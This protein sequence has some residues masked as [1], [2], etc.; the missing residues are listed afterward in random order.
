MFD[1]TSKDALLYSVKPQVYR[2]LG[3]RRIKVL[4]LGSGPRS[5]TPTSATTHRLAELRHEEDGKIFLLSNL[6]VRSMQKKILN[7]YGG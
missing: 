1:G 6:I 3:H 2:R 5:R 4:L 7:T